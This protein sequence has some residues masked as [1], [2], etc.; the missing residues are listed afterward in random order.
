MRPKDLT[1]HLTKITKAKPSEVR[2]ALL[3]AGVDLALDGFP[4]DAV[5][6]FERALTMAKHP[7]ES[8]YLAAA[9]AGLRVALGLDDSAAARTA[10]AETD[11]RVRAACC[12]TAGR[13]WSHRRRT[14]ACPRRA[15]Q[16]IIEWFRHPPR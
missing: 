6:L 10:I 2:S 8:L 7:H 3:D 16:R 14:T 11:A 1:R 13:K 12:S 5:T 4:R 9:V 15:R